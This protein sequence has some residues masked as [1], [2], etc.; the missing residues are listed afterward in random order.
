MG[1][2]LFLVNDMTV[3]VR[4]HRSGH[5]LAMSVAPNLR[6]GRDVTYVCMEIV[7]GPWTPPKPKSVRKQSNL[8]MLMKQ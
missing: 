1:R 4:T 5:V 3:G 2:I 7:L 8:K 6:T